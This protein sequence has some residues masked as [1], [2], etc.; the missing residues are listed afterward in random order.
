VVGLRRPWKKYIREVGDPVRTGKNKK[1]V[2]AVLL[3]K[4]HTMKK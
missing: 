1:V 4:P 3:I 2:L